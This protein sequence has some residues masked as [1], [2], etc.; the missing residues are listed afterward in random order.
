MFF[1]PSLTF[2]GHKVTGAGFQANDN[3]VKA[4]RDMPPPR[5]ITE[6]R[7]F[8][9]MFN[10]LGKFSSQ[11]P[12]KT[13]A[14]NIL[15]KKS[16]EWHW[17]PEQERDF[18]ATKDEICS[19]R[20]LASYNAT[21]ET[22]IR[23][24]AS[25]HGFGA[26]LLLRESNNAEFRPVYFASRSLT[27]AESR[28]SIIEKEAA[29]ITW[30]CKKF[31]KYILGMDDLTIETDQKPLVTL[32]GKKSLDDLPPRI[33]RFRLTLM[34]Y[35]FTISH[36]PGKYMY[37][38]DCLSRASV[39]DSQP[40][41]LCKEAE[42]YAN[43]V[44]SNLPCS[45]R[46]LDQ[47]REG[48][49][50]DEVC[51][52]LMQYTHEGW[53]EKSQL[54]SILVPYYQFRE[55]MSVCNGIL[56][57][58]DRIVVPASLRIEILE[59]IH[60]GHLGIEKCRQR[61]RQSV[62]W[63]GLSAQIESMV[64]NCR[65]CAR[66]KPD[67]AEPLAPTPLPERPWQKAA[68]DLCEIDGKT[69]LVV[70]DYYSRYLEIAKLEQNTKSARVIT[71]LKSIM[72]RHGTFEVLVTDNGPQFAS[73]EFSAFAVDWDF[74]HITSSPR[75]ARANGAAENAVKRF[76]SLYKKNADV[77]KG[78]QAYRAAPLHNGYS[79]SELCM[80]R[81]IR[82]TLPVA[83]HTLQHQRAPDIRVK[84]SNY[85]QNMKLQ[86]DSRHNAREL[87][88]LLPGDKV[89]VKDTNTEGTV[90]KP[91][92]NAP[93][94]HVIATPKGEIRRNR[95]S[96]NKLPD[97]TAPTSPQR[98]AGENATAPQHPAPPSP[99]APGTTRTRSG[100]VSR[101]PDRLHTKELEPNC[102]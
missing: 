38:S 95:R 33:V 75:Y 35:K 86:Y 68:A 14:L 74:V 52:K 53:P 81:R 10:Q 83:P 46:R 17:G 7:R 70:T 1:Q 2:V 39:T 76:K 30:A 101:P 91:A 60:V 47:I 31:D 98:H 73:A 55:Y 57:K 59:K 58:S 43:A 92:D 87:P 54:P 64:K 22:K 26:V 51:T 37:T 66:E 97:S 88:T 21:H 19:P 25:N 40:S 48:Q 65:V 18:D 12:E 56:L 82:T 100:R 49:H 50:E 102:K 93:R 6:L 9:G 96:L 44:L 20:V 45:D 84:E 36:V 32:L 99:S 28:Y 62:W 90:V 78:L 89:L 67:Q 79:P 15:L 80:N 3:K 16:T 4:I 8:L 23:S 77:Y 63:P 5:N 69:F 13:S 29:A 72:A 24:D 85:R 94:S 34:R 71:H 61:A 41:I 42:V 27:P 11:L